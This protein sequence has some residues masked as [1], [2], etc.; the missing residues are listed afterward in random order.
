[1]NKTKIL[2]IIALAAILLACG[3]EEGGGA[4]PSLK[5][6][7]LGFIS[8]FDI[9]EAEFDSKIVNVNE[10]KLTDISYSTKMELLNIFDSFDDT[11]KQLG[12]KKS[13]NI[14]YFRGDSSSKTPGGLHHFAGGINAFI[15]F[16]NL[17]NS[18]G[19]RRDSTTLY[20][21]TYQILDNLAGNNDTLTRAV[22]LE[23]LFS[24]ST[25]VSFAGVLDH[26]IGAS[27]FNM[28]DYYKI[29]LRMND[30]LKI[31]AKSN[32]SLTI[33]ITEP[34]RNSVNKTC[35]VSSKKETICELTVGSGHLNLDDPNEPAN[36]LADFYIKI[37]DNKSSAPPNPYTMQISR[38]R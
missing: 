35:G 7:H 22:D 27:K 18:D 24:N 33:N 31:L 25:Q 29:S 11:L 15:T 5:K 16:K 12:I 23:T 17:K 13:D 34:G 1:M 2:A 9:L 14:L 8:P 37:Y 28:E 20:F 26:K 36:K 10:L 19:Y 4:P 32:D 3:D 6:D 38:L 30:V 21:S